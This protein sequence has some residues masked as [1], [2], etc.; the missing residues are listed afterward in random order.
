MIKIVIETTNDF[1]W[2]SFLEK[3]RHERS[4]AKESYAQ[5]RNHVTEN[6]QWKHMRKLI[7][8]CVS[9]QFNRAVGLPS[10]SPRPV[11]GVPNWKK[12]KLKDG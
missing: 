10:F 6:Q 1:E 8:T 2:F 7:Y 5:K 3:W 11:V 4:I 9:A 12:S